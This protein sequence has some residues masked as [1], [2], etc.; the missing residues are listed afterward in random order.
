MGARDFTTL[1]LVIL[2]DIRFP[3]SKKISVILF[4][5]YIFLTLKKKLNKP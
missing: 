3:W 4:I 2:T 5:F 1:I